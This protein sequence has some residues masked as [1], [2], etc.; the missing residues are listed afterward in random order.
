MRNS[1]AQ[2]YAR[3]SATA[4]AL[5]VLLVAG[6]YWRNLWLAKQAAKK[7]PP[8]VPAAIEQQSNEFSYSKV[9]YS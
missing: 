8:A 6:V 3:W 2:R 5:L 1:E 7:A 4:A 9:D